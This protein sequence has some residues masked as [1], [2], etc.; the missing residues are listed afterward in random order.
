MLERRPTRALQNKFRFI[1]LNVTFNSENLQQLAREG[2]AEHEALQPHVQRD[3]RRRVHAH[4]ARAQ[5]HPHHQQRHRE[6]VRVAEQLEPIPNIY[7]YKSKLIAEMY[8]GTRITSS[9]NH[10]IFG[11][12]Q[13]G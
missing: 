13:I 2:Q 7:L 12:H 1:S 9:P 3:E 4:H 6:A 5:H 8:I 11:L 10:Q